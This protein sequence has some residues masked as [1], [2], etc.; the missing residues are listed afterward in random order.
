MLDM[1]RAYPGDSRDVM[2]ARKRTDEHGYGAAHL[3][4]PTVILVRRHTYPQQFIDE[5]DTIE[6]HLDENAAQSMILRGAGVGYSSRPMAGRARVRF[7]KS[8]AGDVRQRS[9][10]VG[11]GG[12]EVM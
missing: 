8:L 6:A 2:Q 3:G 9:A 11:C 7:S 1:E 12:S 4:I 5:F 10:N